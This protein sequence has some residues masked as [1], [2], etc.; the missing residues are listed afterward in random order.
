MN[1][2]SIRLEPSS[3]FNNQSVSNETSTVQVATNVFDGCKY[4]QTAAA[5]WLAVL[6][7]TYL[8]YAKF[9]PTFSGF[10]TRFDINRTVQPQMLARGMQFPIKEENGAYYLCSEKRFKMWQLI[11]FLGSFETLLFKSI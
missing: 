6:G 1:V 2:Q 8:S 3:K 4:T 7:T 9:V 11:L 5:E 10:R